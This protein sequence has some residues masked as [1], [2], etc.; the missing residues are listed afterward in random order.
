MDDLERLVEPI[1]LAIEQS[2][3]NDC[4][5]R[6]FS[7]DARTV[8]RAILTS[9][10]L[11]A[12]LEAAELRGFNRGLEEAAGIA[13]AEGDRL[14]GTPTRSLGFYV[15]LGGHYAAQAI[16]QRMETSK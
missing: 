3:E 5:F 8:A 12:H 2:A 16:R 6:I 14:R 1:A 11:L 4:G 15:H 10:A 9:P 13:D 7:D